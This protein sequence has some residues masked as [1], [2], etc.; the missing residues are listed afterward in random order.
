MLGEK[1]KEGDS[2][3]EE[4]DAHLA[5][6][7]LKA[8]I[9]SAMSVGTGATSLSVRCFVGCLEGEMCCI[10]RGL[11]VVDEKERNRNRLDFDFCELGPTALRTFRSHCAVHHI[12]DLPFRHVTPVTLCYL[13]IL[14]SFTTRGVRR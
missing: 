2:R 6:L 13:S 8:I 12:S 4:G 1:I 3:G 11:D 9:L 14:R 5:C 10:A 7:R